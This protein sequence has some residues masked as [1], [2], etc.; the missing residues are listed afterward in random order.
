MLRRKLSDFFFSRFY[1]YLNLT[2][3]FRSMIYKYLK[4]HKET[5]ML[6]SQQKKA[7]VDFYNS[8]RSNE[9][10]EP[11]VTLMIHLASAMALSCYP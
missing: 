10:L 8:A 6:P 7:Y 4:S 5:E 3:Q 9:I 2:L 1:F 11:K